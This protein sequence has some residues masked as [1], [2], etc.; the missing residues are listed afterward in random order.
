MKTKIKKSIAKISLLEWF[1]YIIT[2]IGF[3]VSNHLL[4][5]IAR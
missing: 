2:F 4:L 3:V 5:H 1:A